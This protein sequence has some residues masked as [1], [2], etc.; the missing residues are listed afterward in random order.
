M[1]ERGPKGRLPL[2]KSNSKSEMN[3]CSYE[4]LINFYIL[5]LLRN[6]SDMSGKRAEAKP[7]AS[8]ASPTTKNLPD[9]SSQRPKPGQGQKK[10]KRSGKFWKKKL[11]NMVYCLKFF[12]ETGHYTNFRFIDTFFIL[13]RILIDDR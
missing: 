1:L 13:L 9:A 4:I 12:F 10:K 8:N 5:F 3:L 6:N 2:H 7:A 11:L